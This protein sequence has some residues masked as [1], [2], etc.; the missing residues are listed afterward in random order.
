MSRL[1]ALLAWYLTNLDP[2]PDRMH[3]GPRVWQATGQ[4]DDPELGLGSRLGSPALCA[5]AARWLEASPTSI[6]TEPLI[7]ECQHVGRLDGTI[8][9]AC[10]VRDETGR[11]VAESGYRQ[12]H[13]QRYRWP[14][15]AA[16]DRV[17]HRPVRPGYPP[18]DVVLRAVAMA[19]DDL[20]GVISAL[21]RR[22]PVMGDRVIFL[23]HLAS[24]LSRVRRAYRVAPACR[25]SSGTADRAA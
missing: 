4:P 7:V 19:G 20:D 13:T 11:P 2:P 12:A 16:V 25:P 8:C 6:V 21:A 22:Y 17:G 3:A 18:L 15:R 9:E 10:A 24:A 14:M 1:A 5:E 23:G